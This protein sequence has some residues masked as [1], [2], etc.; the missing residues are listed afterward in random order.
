MP[1]EEFVGLVTRADHSERTRLRSSATT[2]ATLKPL[3]Q[4]LL[5]GAGPPPRSCGTRAGFTGD[6]CEYGPSGSGR[7]RNS[8]AS[9]RGAGRRGQHGKGGRSNRC[10]ARAWFFGQDRGQ[11]AGQQ[12]AQQEQHGGEHDSS[13]V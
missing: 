9:R 13:R 2:F 1:G 6:V 8:R 11:A 12:E 5:R 7:D 3:C 10:G 4:D